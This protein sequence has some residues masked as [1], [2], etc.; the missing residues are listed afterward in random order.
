[1][2]AVAAAA[3]MIGVLAAAGPA[4]AGGPTSLVLWTGGQGPGDSAT[5]VLVKANGTAQLLAPV[6]STTGTVKVV[7]TFTPNSSQLAA[8]RAAAEGALTGQNVA[9]SSTVDGFYATATVKV[10]GTT[11]SLLGNN[12]LPPKLEA[13]L[14]A[15]VTAVPASAPGARA[16]LERPL[17]RTAAHP[18]TAACASGAPP[19]TR[20]ARELTL[21]QAAQLGILKLTSKGGFN[22]DAMA[23]DGAFKDVPAPT[24][25]RLD[26]ELVSDTPGIEKA[27]EA[28]VEGQL[29]G[30]KVTS[31][32]L[33]N[34]PVRF[35]L[36]VVRRGTSGTTPRSCFHELAI[37][38]DKNLR[39]GV[40]GLGPGPESG[41]LNGIDRGAW[42]HEVMHLAGLDDRYDDYFVYGGGKKV[43]KMPEVGLE[44]DALTAE[45]KKLGINP[46]NGFLTSR[47]HKGYAGNLMAN[48]KGKLNQADLKHFAQLGQDTLIIHSKPGDLLTSKAG[49]QQNVVNGQSFDMILRRGGPPVHLDGM[50]VYC[51]DLSRH[52]PAKGIVYDVL[53]PVDELGNPAM[54]ALARVMEVINSRERGS[55]SGVPAG[56]QDA[57]WRIT[58]DSPPGAAARAILEEAGVPPDTDAVKFNAPHFNNPNA[59][60]PNT[61]AVTPGAVLPALDLGTPPAR[62]R[63]PRPRL[64]GAAM[65]PRSSRRARRLLFTLQVTLA[66]GSGDRLTLALERRSGRRF[67]R[68]RRLGRQRVG[69]G[70]TALSFVLRGLSPGRYRVRVGAS[71]RQVRFATFT[72]T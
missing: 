45:L 1:M 5:G 44:G 3:A 54:A 51:S 62:V 53:G 4:H 46:K 7:K 22:G 55:F 25:V 68:V 8:I 2:R 31:G 38:N 11:R 70:L 71:R 37:S 36:N 17:A 9:I 29:G 41:E 64:R 59:G 30:Y 43:A 15:V 66:A 47:P 32:P 24:V 26:I 49:D 52:V 28:Q 23:V 10:G 56:A 12:A 65:L 39:D 16:I 6:N 35:D 67:R 72:V 42:T 63:A 33:K 60:S 40:S 18:D 14:G 21:K 19:P 20:V 27:F 48:Q 58:D 34:Q 50:T 69:D 57:I 13:L 61:G